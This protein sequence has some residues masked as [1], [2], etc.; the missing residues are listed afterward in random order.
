MLG[1][2]NMESNKFSFCGLEI[3]Y[4][5]CSH[6]MRKWTGVHLHNGPCIPTKV[7][8]FF[9]YVKNT[10]TNV[11]VVFDFYA[12]SSKT[13]LN[14]KDLAY[15]LYFFCDCAIKG[16]IPFYEYFSLSP[17]S[18]VNIENTKADYKLCVS[19]FHRIKKVIPDF[20]DKKEYYMKQLLYWF[21]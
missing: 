2:T 11:S 15:I 21:L 6:V 3:S 14:N 8:H 12:D 5:F 1:D 17:F 9:V 7:S 20:M 16:N 4:D 19:D 13:E 18:S 10:E